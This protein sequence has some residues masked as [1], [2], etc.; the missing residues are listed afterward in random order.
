MLSKN[1][2]AVNTAISRGSVIFRCAL[3]AA[4]TFRTFLSS[5][6]VIMDSLLKLSLS[7]RPKEAAWTKQLIFSHLQDA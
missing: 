1:S 7:Q 5:A 3:T 4:Q 6:A 2:V